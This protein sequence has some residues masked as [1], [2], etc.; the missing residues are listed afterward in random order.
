M[1]VDNAQLAAFSAVIRE[2]SFEGA[3]RKL[4]VTASAVSQRIKQLEDRLGQ[5]LVL[6]GSPCEATPAGKT[7]LRFTE[8]I[9]F[10]ESELFHD[11][12]VFGDELGMES[13]L[14]IVVNVDSLD[15]WFLNVMESVCDDSFITF[16]VRIEDQDYSAALLRE[17]AVMAA[18]SGSPVAVQGCRVEFLGNM[19]YL[20]LA[21]PLFQSKY[22]SNGVGFESLSSAPMLVFNRKDDTQHDFVRALISQEIAPPVHC[23]PT[24]HSFIEAIR[25][26]FGWGM[27]PED[28]VRSHME[29]GVLV[30]ITPGQYLDVPL[31]WH[32]W[33]FNSKNL[34]KLS[35]IVR[36]CAKKYLRS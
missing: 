19:R 30:D 8:Q 12:G 36:E 25:R 33:R 15:G 24:S 6:R 11:L 23:L 34:E 22:F 1:R 14:P 18:V 3:A 20:A 4:H 28:M 5:V 21:S 27:A 29:A 7:L 26:G 31:Y 13:R 35:S 10:L 2:G 16:D 17:G 9:D 32:S